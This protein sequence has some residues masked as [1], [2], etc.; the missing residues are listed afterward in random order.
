MNRR[1][2][3]F[4][5]VDHSCCIYS[6]GVMFMINKFSIIA[7]VHTAHKYR[8]LDAVNCHD[9][10]SS[11]S[12]A[13]RTIFQWFFKRKSNFFSPL[14]K[15][16]LKAIPLDLCKHLKF[17]LITSLCFSASMIRV[18]CFVCARCIKFLFPSESQHSSHFQ[19]FTSISS[20]TP[21]S[22]PPF[23]LHCLRNFVH[24]TLSPALAYWYSYEF[25]FVCTS[26]CYC[27]C[28]CFTVAKVAI[29]SSLAIATMTTTTTTHTGTPK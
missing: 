19:S 14:S 16:Q 4:P 17:S 25:Q 7:S 5:F 6:K 23:I 1:H 24:F 18:L 3:N 22:F 8:N 10:L 15:I 12:R 13:K 29:L 20:H 9:R 26:T 27:Q 11:L 21:V 2:N 28:L